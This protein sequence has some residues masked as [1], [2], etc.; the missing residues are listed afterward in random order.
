MGLGVEFPPWWLFSA[1]WGVLVP[2][3]LAQ[4]P[5]KGSR[6]RLRG[7]RGEGAAEKGI[8]I[9]ASVRGGGERAKITSNAAGMDRLKPDPLA[10]AALPLLLRALIAHRPLKPPRRGGSRS[11]VHLAAGG[12]LQ[13]HIP[14]QR[15]IP[16][17]RGPPS[18]P[19]SGREKPLS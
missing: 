15:L 13:K 9:I 8:R 19:S 3:A 10:R 16:E 7:F 18:D 6:A 2:T 12:T 17:P 1:V 11:Y 4:T 5:G 14:G